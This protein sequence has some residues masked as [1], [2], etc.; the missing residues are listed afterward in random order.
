MS[1]SYDLS[2]STKWANLADGSHTVTLKAKASNYGTSSFSNSVTV[3]KG[4]SGYVLEAGTYKWVDHV[5]INV[6]LEQSISF[7]SNSTAFNIISVIRGSHMQYGNISVFLAADGGWQDSAYKTIT[8]STDQTVSAEFY[9]WAITGG[10]L[11]KQ[12]SETWVLNETIS[13]IGGLALPYTQTEFVSNSKQFSAIECTTNKTVEMRYYDSDGVDVFV[14]SNVWMY[15]DNYRTVTF[16][17][18]PTGDLL[19][20]L[21]ANGTKQG[22]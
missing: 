2:T 9:E 14:Y 10:N 12:E 19:T 17:T 15:S 6:D 18:P 11:V 20:W 16:S 3:T 22:G 13:S 5:P 8:L 21:Q 7:D 1:K 4:S